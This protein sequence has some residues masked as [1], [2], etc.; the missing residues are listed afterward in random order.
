[1]CCFNVLVCIGFVVVT[2]LRF[3]FNDLVWM[4]VLCLLCVILVLGAGL[5][6]FGL[7]LVCCFGVFGVCMGT[8]PVVCF[9]CMVFVLAVMG[10]VFLSGRLW[11][12]GKSCFYF[13]G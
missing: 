9:V 1:M 8:V 3:R 4:F 12:F 10:W 13:D 6:V 5:F 7:V 2:D 11:V